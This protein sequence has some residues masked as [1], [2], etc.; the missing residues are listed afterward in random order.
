[1]GALIC[2]SLRCVRGGFTLEVDFLRIAK[3]EKIAVLGENGCGKTTL[4]QVLAGLQ[5]AAGEIRRDAARWDR[6]SPEERAVFL[7]YLPQE[8]ELL[9][10][11]KVRELMALTLDKS[12]LLRGEARQALLEALELTELMERPY[13]ALSGGERRRA[14]LARTFGR[15]AEFV[16][17]DEPTASLDMRHAAMIMRYA[18]GLEAGVV[19]AVHDLNGALQAFDRFLLMR[20]GRVVFDKRKDE[21]DGAELE[22]IYGIRLARHGGYFVPGA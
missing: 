6:L 9:F 19:A 1:M 8:Q 21:L 18:A 3:G 5:P 7:S 15:E 12:R 17:L 2:K 10:P 14:M 22:E 16:I 11:L 4:L 20:H 13:P